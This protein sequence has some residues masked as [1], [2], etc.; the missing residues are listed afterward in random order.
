MYPG[1][2]AFQQFLGLSCSLGH[3]FMAKEI[4]L[5]I[6]GRSKSR[7]CQ[8]KKRL[9]TI[10]W[11]FRWNILHIFSLDVWILVLLFCKIIL[12]DISKKK[13]SHWYIVNSGKSQHFYSILKH[14]TC[15]LLSADFYDLYVVGSNHSISTQAS[16]H[17]S[18]CEPSKMWY[19]G[20]LGG[21]PLQPSYFI[22]HLP[23]KPPEPLSPS[24]LCPGT[25]LGSARVLDSPE[26]KTAGQTSRKHCSTWGYYS[27]LFLPSSR[28]S[29]LC[30]RWCE[31]ELC[32]R[33]FCC[34]CCCCCWTWFQQ[35]G[36]WRGARLSLLMLYFFPSI[37]SS[38]RVSINPR[39]ADYQS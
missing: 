33:T 30:L 20:S 11:N 34:C 37:L 17:P 6:I 5:S 38:S 12:L 24:Q 21:S 22:D 39:C 10:L 29:Q 15:L 31:R 2:G 16:F 36:D 32:Q 23:L 27:T 19:T 9:S 18:S 35:C 8:R 28:N 14:R 26:G 25:T 13:K 7:N 3:P 1:Q 4:F